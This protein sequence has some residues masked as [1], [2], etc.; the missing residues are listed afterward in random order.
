MTPCW[1]VAHGKRPAP[2]L[3][4]ASEHKRT[5]A[6]LLTCAPWQPSELWSHLREP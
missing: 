4:L 3:R 2:S 5:T 1:I 6:S